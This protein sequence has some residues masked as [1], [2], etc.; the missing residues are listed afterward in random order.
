MPCLISRSSGLMLAAVPRA[1][2]LAPAASASRQ[3]SKDGST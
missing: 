1:T 2:K 3:R